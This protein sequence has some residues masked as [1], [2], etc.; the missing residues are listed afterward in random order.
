MLREHVVLVVVRL[1]TRFVCTSPRCM[2]KSSCSV[3]EWFID[4]FI[5]RFYLPVVYQLYNWFM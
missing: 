5:H 1:Y 2:S 3:V 4:R